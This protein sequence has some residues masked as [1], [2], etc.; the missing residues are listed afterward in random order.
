MQG[1]SRGLM[2]LAALL[3]ILAGPLSA[4]R[5]DSVA[6]RESDT[7]R[8]WSRP[9]N[10]KDARGVV[11]RVALDS[12]AFFMTSGWRGHP[13]TVVSD[14]PSLD[15]VDVL[16]GRQR[17]PGFMTTEA[18]VGGVVGA[19][20]GAAVAYGV[21]RLI[22]ARYATAEDG[23]LTRDDIRIYVRPGAQIGGGLGL[24]AG[25]IDGLG[26]REIWRRVR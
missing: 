4:Q 13:R 19:A 12:V 11:S 18:V 26:P 3:P 9:L 1:Y 14:L 10:L 6:I 25:L 17:S 7:V 15:R 24:I 16:V 8:V 22:Y 21:L 5:T 23:P 20:T 2:G